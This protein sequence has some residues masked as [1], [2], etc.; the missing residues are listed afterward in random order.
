MEPF[1]RSGRGLP[2]LIPFN[3][4]MRKERFKLQN[5]LV[6]PW[7]SLELGNFLV[8]L[9]PEVFPRSRKI[10]ISVL[11]Y[12]EVILRGV[13][14]IIPLYPLSSGY[15][16]SSTHHLGGTRREK[17]I[18]SWAELENHR[19]ELRGI[20]YSFSGSSKREDRNGK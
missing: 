19:S 20:L 3:G 2:K 13:E 14:A 11:N 1:F 15:W 8:A 4:C 16:I 6:F 17:K 10:Y 12:K 9:L 7:L 18:Q 5:C